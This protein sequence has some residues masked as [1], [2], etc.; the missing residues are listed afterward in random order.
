MGFAEGFASGAALANNAIAQYRAAEQ[1]QRRREIEEELRKLAQAGV[2]EIPGTLA[3]QPQRADIQTEIDADPAL[4]AAAQQNT[5]PRYEYLGKTYDTRPDEATMLRDRQLAMA[6]VYEKYGDPAAGIALRRDVRRD[7][8]AEEE[9]KAA[10]LRRRALEL[11][12]QG[13]ERAAKDDE[14]RRAV[15]ERMRQWWDRRLTN[16]DGT[17]RLPTPTDFLSA[18]QQRIY[19]LTDA[20]RLDDAAQAYKEHNAQSFIKIQMDSEQR[21]VDGERALQALH[22]GNTKGVLDWYN[23]Y[24]PDGGTATGI[25]Q[26]KDGSISIERTGPDGRPIRPLV[27]PGGMRQLDAS[28]RQAF[29]PRAMYQW[30]QQ[31][32]ENNL[33]LRSEQRAGAAEGRAQAEFKAGN[34]RRELDST[35]AGLQRELID[36]KTTPERRQQV[37]TLLSEAKGTADKD[38]PAQVK[39]AQAFVAAGLRP[40]MRSA[41]EFAMTAKDKSP[42]AL[43]AEIYKSALTANMGNAKAARE[44]TEE[45]MRYLAQSQAA[46]APAA[47]AAVKPADQATAHA[48][49]RDAVARGAP[50]DAVNARLRSMGFAPLP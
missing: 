44:A 41:L 8:V 20:G 47:P 22:Q 14:T 42:E 15:D 29:D 11:E 45:A 6:G 23:T 37:R 40:D 16:P 24:A 19:A 28:I 3:A 7:Q 43:R 33:R 46:P 30:S 50:K 9:A 26:G 38:A 34:A 48:Q 13:K 12:V 2:K 4:A 1:E 35:L 21:K 39:L 18:T 25:V 10:P 5:A 27:M 36:P 31:E 49:A 32:F 17:K